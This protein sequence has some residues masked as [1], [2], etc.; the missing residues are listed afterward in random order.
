MKSRRFGTVILFPR[1]RP[2]RVR[3]S[4]E[5]T[6]RLMGEMGFSARNEPVW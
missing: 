2:E 6:Y 5:V 3:L 4:R 1:F